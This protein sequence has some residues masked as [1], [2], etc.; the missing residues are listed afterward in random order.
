MAT[1]ITYWVRNARDYLY[2]VYDRSI[3]YVKTQ[4][5]HRTYLEGV[6]LAALWLL[7]PL[8]ITIGCFFKTIQDYRTRNFKTQKE[9][10]VAADKVDLV[11]DKK[12]LN[13]MI[14]FWLY[15]DAHKQIAYESKK[16]RKITTDKTVSDDDKRKAIK[17]YLLDGPNNGTY[18][19][20]L[21]FRFFETS[22]DKAYF[23]ENPE[24]NTP[25]IQ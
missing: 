2:Y 11:T 19:M 18:T 23:I 21:A 5:P 22:K 24:T 20:F 12:D 4:P 25:S 3:D 8:S 9:I 14:N 1:F 15:G 6:T 16:L 13:F 17:N 7:T 10:Q